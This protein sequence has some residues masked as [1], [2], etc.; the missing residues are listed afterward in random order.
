MKLKCKAAIA[1]LEVLVQ[2]IAMVSKSVNK[3]VTNESK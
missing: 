1:A 3:S 2:C